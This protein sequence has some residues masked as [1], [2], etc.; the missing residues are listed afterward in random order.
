PVSAHVTVRPAEA[1]HGAEVTYTLRAPSEGGRETTSV[2][3]EIP[4]GVTV[5]S[6]DGAAE[7]Y[8]TKKAGDRVSAILWKVKIPAGERKDFKF[9]AR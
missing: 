6:V 8:E 1:D 3:L 2:E 4:T 7:T 9:I 5:V